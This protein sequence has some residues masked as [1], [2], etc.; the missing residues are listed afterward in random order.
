[1]NPFQIQVGQHRRSLRIEP[2]RVG[3]G[4][5]MK[6]RILDNHR[7]ENWLQHPSDGD[8]PSGNLLGEMVVHSQKTFSFTGEGDFSGEDL[9]SIATQ[10]SLHPSF[11]A[12]G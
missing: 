3:E 10:I 8:V 4:E 1:M 6:F 11:H 2:I 7:D 12:T 9:L 5:P